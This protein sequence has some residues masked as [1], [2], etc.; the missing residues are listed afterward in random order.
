MLAIINVSVR[1]EL[2]SLRCPRCGLA[3]EL[4]E[5]RCHVTLGCRRCRVYVRARK[6]DVV[7]LMVAQRT[8]NW[9]QLIERM[10]LDYTRHV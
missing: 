8:L 7:R 6:R 1:V 5:N 9:R 2:A 4:V 3:L 10:Y